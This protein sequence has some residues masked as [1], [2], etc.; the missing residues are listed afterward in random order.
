MSPEMKHAVLRER[1]AEKALGEAR[2]LRVAAFGDVEPEVSSATL[3]DVA[4]VD[5]GRVRMG[6][7]AR[8]HHQETVVHCRAGDGDHLD[9]AHGFEPRTEDLRQAAVAKFPAGRAEHRAGF[10]RY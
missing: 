5:G 1:R 3:E 10:A 4:D 9:R 2:P 6:L 7:Q 8:G